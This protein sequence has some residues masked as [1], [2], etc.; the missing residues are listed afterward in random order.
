MVSVER[1]QE[2]Q[3]DLDRE[4]PYLI[5]EQDP[6]QEWPQYGQV[7]NDFNFVYLINK[8]YKNK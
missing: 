3:D 8:S 6:P 7:K 4:A 5:P 2:Y 1:I